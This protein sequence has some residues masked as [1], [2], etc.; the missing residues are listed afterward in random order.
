MKRSQYLSAH[1]AGFVLAF[2]L[3]QTQ[4]SAQTKVAEQDEKG[5]RRKAENRQ[6]SMTKSLQRARRR[7]AMR[8]R[9]R[10]YEPLIAAAA[11]KHKVDPASLWTIGY[12]ETRFRARARSPKGAQGLMQFMPETGRRFNLTNPDDA[13][14]SIDAA[15]RYVAA[16][17]RQFGSRLD[18]ILAAYNSGETSV[19]FRSC[20]SSD[21]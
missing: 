2:L 17:T 19:A 6:R 14:Q 1:A 21:R 13:A 9:A 3:W 4:A 18:L 5:S 11:A 20:K 10:L 12:L 15:A 8:Q 16:L 7:S